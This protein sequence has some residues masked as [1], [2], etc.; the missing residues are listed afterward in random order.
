MQH[1]ANLYSLVADIGGTNTRVALAEGRKLVEGTVRRYSNADFPGLETVLRRYIADEGGVDPRAACVAVAGPVRDGRATM[2][3]LD[4]AIDK[5][6]LRR[7]TGAEGVDILNDLQAQGHALGHI[8]PANIHTIIPFPA[9]QPNATRLV[10]GVGTGFNAAPVFDGPTGRLVAASESGH[11][12]LPVR[13]ATDLRLC[14]Y[15]ETLHG[16]PAVEDVL[17]GRGLE[18]VYAWLCDEAGTPR[19]VAAQDIMSACAAGSDPRATE[20]AHVF[21]RMLGT[22]TGNLALIQLPF[23]G[24]Y[25]VGGVAR[26]FAPY[27]NDFGFVGAFLDKGRFAGF[28]GNFGVGVIEDDYAALTGCAAHLVA[29]LG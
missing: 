6:T 7:A 18:R 14:A 22:V 17:S 10:V 23:G 3:N 29:M 25:L 27:L 21:S 28:M 9:A 4:W 26:A 24:V 8:D 13:D 1:P 15:I 12:N 20:A 2:T 5:D 16:F 11:V 19:E